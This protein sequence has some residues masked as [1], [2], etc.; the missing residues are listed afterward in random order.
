MIERKREKEKDLV[1]IPFTGMMA[2]DLWKNTL[3]HTNSIR[4]KKSIEASLNFSKPRL[5]TLY[6][7]PTIGN[8]EAS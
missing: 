5:S 1:N 4:S 6:N 2:S 7:L 3:P 8:V